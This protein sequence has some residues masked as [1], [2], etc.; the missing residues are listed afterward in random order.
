MAKRVRWP[1]LIVIVGMAVVAVSG[2]IVWAASSSNANVRGVVLFVGDSNI[3][4]ST[5]AIDLAL[6]ANTHKD[7]GYV[8][9][10]ESRIGSS[11]RTSDCLNPTGC[12]TTNYWK[13]KIS[14]TLLRINPN[15]I[16]TDLGINDTTG[17]GTSTTSGYAGYGLKIDWFMSLIPRTKPVMWT[18]LPC[19]IEPPGLLKGCQAVNQALSAATVRWSNLWVL[20][21]AE[22]ANSHPTYMLT[23]G[24]DVHLSPAGSA[25]WVRVVLGLLDARFPPP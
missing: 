19:T 24:K 1:G 23:P 2:S 16:V 7:N 8:P 13:L 3:S 9:V 25:A 18:N 6:T 4:L 17:N 22:A 15:A 10:L 20:N 21:W 14:Q 5:S 11:I 12:T